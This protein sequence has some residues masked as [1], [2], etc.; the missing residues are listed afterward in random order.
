MKSQQIRLAD[1]F[2]IGP[3]M[4]WAADRLWR[5]YKDRNLATVAL[6]IFA[7]ATVVYNARNWF[8]LRS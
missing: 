3:T 5:V 1:V 7:V 2:V 4:L 6:A 8:R